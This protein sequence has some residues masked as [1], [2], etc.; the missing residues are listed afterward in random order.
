M[1]SVYRVDREHCSDWKLTGIT[2]PRSLPPTRLA[3]GGPAWAGTGSPAPAHSLS[4]P[5]PDGSSGPRSRLW[6]LSLQHLADDS[7]LT[8][9]H[10]GDRFPIAVQPENLSR[11]SGCEIYLSIG[12]EEQTARQPREQGSDSSVRR[13]LAR[14]AVLGGYSALRA[15]RNDPPS[16]LLLCD[17]LRF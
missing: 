4:R 17:H 2:T 16:A 13:Q 3:S 15:K 14:G 9:A 6:K 10:H 7:G 12:T 11:K 8:A 1:G 5:T